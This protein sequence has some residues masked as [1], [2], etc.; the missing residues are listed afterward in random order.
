MQNLNIQKKKIKL[1]PL[2]LNFPILNFGK[3]PKTIGIVVGLHGVETSGF[4]VLKEL[5]ALKG[6]LTNKVK[7]IAGANPPGLVMLSRFNELDLPMD[8][9]DPNRAFPGDP[10]GSVQS[11]IN[12]LVLKELGGCD[13]VLDLHNYSNL[14]GIFPILALEETSESKF[15]G[16]LKEE[17]LGFLNKLAPDFAF[18]ANTKQAAARGFSGTLNESLNQ[19]GTPNLSLEM[20]GIEFLQESQIKNLAKSIVSAINGG[21]EKGKSIKAPKLINTEIT[22][23]GVAGVFTPKVFPPKTVKKGELLGEIFD[24]FQGKVLP[25]KSPKGGLLVVIKKKNFVRVGEFLFELGQEVEPN[26]PT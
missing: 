2:D 12:T 22:R 1:G 16:T 20:P 25:V 6:S 10:K 14:G 9:K 3:G 11:Q 21:G 15:K 24:P 19:L 5:L 13:F 26:F 4:Y 18:F 7:V 23:S 17:T 8:V